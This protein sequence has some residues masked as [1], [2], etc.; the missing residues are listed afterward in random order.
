MS[1]IIEEMQAESFERGFKMGQL[2]VLSELVD[3]GILIV[4]PA[5]ERAGM[6]PDQFASRTG[7]EGFSSN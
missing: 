2:E 4:A 5:A 1:K 6:T 3:E 7:C